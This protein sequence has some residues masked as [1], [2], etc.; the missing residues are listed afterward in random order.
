MQANA[1]VRFA[2]EDSPSAANAAAKLQ[3]IFAERYRDGSG[4]RPQP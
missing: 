1:A 3:Q 2:A 4:K